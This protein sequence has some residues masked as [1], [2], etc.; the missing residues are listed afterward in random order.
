M[1]PLDTVPAAQDSGY[2]ISVTIH[3]VAWERV[4]DAF[5]E[6]FRRYARIFARRSVRKATRVIAVSESTAQDLRELYGVPPERIRVVPNGVHP[7]TRPPVARE[8]LVLSVGIR[9]PRKRIGVLVEGHA[10]YWESAPP[11]PPPAFT[12]V[13]TTG[14]VTQGQMKIFPLPMPAGKKVVIRTTGTTD[15]DLYIQFG[16]EPTTSNYINRGYTSSGNETVTYTATS[17]GT[18]YIGV[19]GY[20][21]GNRY[22]GDASV[23]RR[24]GPWGVS[25]GLNIL[26]EQAE[27]WDGRVRAEEGNLGRTDLLLAAGADRRLGTAGSVFVTVKVPLVTDAEGSQVDYPLIFSFGFVH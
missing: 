14:S 26:R 13:N 2:A 6:N 25:L 12:H 19:H 24:F 5:P 27:R 21:A 11:T 4:P 10:R 3:D 7:D 18:L 22:Y 23:A 8:P 17:N 1:N 9:E 15:I 16:G 20:Q